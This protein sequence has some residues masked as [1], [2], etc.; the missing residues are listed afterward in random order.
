MWTNAASTRF[1]LM[2]YF[3]INK[4]TLEAIGGV[5]RRNNSV[6]T[7]IILPLCWNGRFALAGEQYE[8]NCGSAGFSN[9]TTNKRRD[10]TSHKTSKRPASEMPRGIDARAF[11][12]IAG[13]PRLYPVEQVSL[14]AGLPRRWQLLKAWAGAIRRLLSSSRVT[15][16]EIPSGMTFGAAPAS[17]PCHQAVTA[18]P[19]ASGL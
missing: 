11:A 10:T 16:Y 2:R 17:E 14:K 3:H 6:T 19:T 7:P 12:G 13:I 8:A 9:I 5:L 15:S 1:I 4:V 18:H